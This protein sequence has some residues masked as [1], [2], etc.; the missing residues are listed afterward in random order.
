MKNS[1]FKRAFAVAAAAPLAL[2]QCLTVANAANIS[3]AD[4][5]AVEDETVA[6]SG[7]AIT[8]DGEGGLTYI[9]PDKEIDG[10][11]YYMFGDTALADIAEF[12]ED[13]YE[14]T[15][16]STWNET[17]FGAIASQSGS[18]GTFEIADILAEAVGK[19]GNYKQIANQL[20]GHVGDVNYTVADNGDV[21]LTCDVTDVIP[22]FTAGVKNTLGGAIRDINAKY[23]VNIDC[24]STFKGIV[25]SGTLTVVVKA[26]E[27]ANGTTVSAEV[28]F[29]AEDGK[30]YKGAQ[31]VAYGLAKFDALEAA[32]DKAIDATFD[33]SKI[34]EIADSKAKVAD[35]LSFYRKQV[36]RATSLATKG[37]TKTT[38]LKE[39]G[40]FANLLT[41]VKNSSYGKKVE[42]KLKKEL[43][44][45]G[46]DIAA[47]ATFN[48]YYDKAISELAAK[49]FDVQ[50]TSSDLGTF[51]DGLYDV[52]AQLL[53][54]SATFSAKFSDAEGE[55]VKAY[56][57]SEYGLDVTDYYKTI[58]IKADYSKAQ[59]G[60]GSVDVQLKRVVIA[61]TTTTTSS[62]TTSETTTTTTS[63]T[64]TETTTESTTTETT[65]ASTTSEEPTT[66]TKVV[67][68]SVVNYVIN[69]KTGFYLNIDEEFNKDQI[70]SIY[71]SIDASDVS[72][73]DA[74]EVVD[75]KVITKGQAINI[76]DSVDFGKQ[77]P[78]N[79]FVD[80]EYKFAHE[81][82]LYATEDIKNG[83]Q[84]IAKAG[85]KL[86][87]ANG[88]EVTVI[89]YVG[90]KGDGDLNFMADSRDASLVLTWYAKM[91]T[92]G[93]PD[94]EIFSNSDLITEYDADG[95]RV[96]KAEFDPMLDQLAAF[97]CDTD[98]ENAEDNWYA[99]KPARK[100]D[101][102]DASFILKMYSWASTGEEPNR[103]TWN[104]V[105]GENFAK[106]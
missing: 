66:T 79:V 100:I 11:D 93:D 27:L 30:E 87:Q 9:T 22:E 74:D 5:A 68:E 103:T 17:L 31:I 91:S 21:T 97:L 10:K 89:A 20:A 8:L 99:L 56:F 48:K 28:S 16:D 45:C 76:T 2:T 12:T 96:L 23:G 35:S 33:A 46:A 37:M 80:G 38:E 95:N 55:D 62:T 41:A 32:A 77:T 105:L 3:N 57:L 19:A 15:K 63:E 61:Q 67:R 58:D 104:E 78:A 54:G 13:E 69:A 44:T 24:D 42:G 18:T 47:N 34:A 26:S 98:N 39:F 82:L 40:T 101:A 72:Y 4:I 50:I 106:H 64:T 102:K 6:A 1:L 88:D 49:G 92:G 14:I 7:K 65:T 94:T 90:V 83:D 25:A 71:A 86:V 43:P 29:K 53:G 60:E 85:D 51:A 52:T 84:V 59:A 70:D 73:N 81:I 36:N 75:V